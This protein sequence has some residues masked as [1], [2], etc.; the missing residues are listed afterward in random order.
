[1]ILNTPLC[2]A[3]AHC[4]SMNRKITTMCL[5]EIFC[6]PCL[7]FRSG[8]P[9]EHTEQLTHMITDAKRHSRSIVI[10][11]L[12]LRNAFGE[13][14]HNLLRHRIS[15]SA[16]HIQRSVR[17]HL[18]RLTY[19]NR[20]EQGLDIESGSEQGSVARWSLFLIVV[21]LVL[22]HSHAH[23]A[24]KETGE[25]RVH[26]GSWREFKRMLMAPVYAVFQSVILAKLT[27]AAPAWI[28]FANQG[29]ID[30]IDSFL[31]KCVCF[32][33][34]PP[35]QVSFRDLVESHEEKLF[36]AITSNPDH[37]LYS[38]LPPKKKTTYN[39]R[40]RAHDFVIPGR[41]LKLRDSNFILRIVHKNSF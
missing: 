29:D 4:A 13:V 7:F 28:G 8:V 24:R 2:P 21:Q 31:R 18:Y 5:F 34:A 39:M 19:Q 30:R 20:S 35:D 16:F 32:N 3:V 25:A 12:D 1:M 9:A 14:H 40:K 27:Y 6:P 10:T 38:L 26:L 36:N 17:R 15:S 22:Q 11:L 23:P 37:V 33:F 41:E